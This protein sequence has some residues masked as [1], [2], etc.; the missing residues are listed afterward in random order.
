M[1]LAVISIPFLMSQYR[2]SANLNNMERT[3]FYKAQYPVV[4]ISRLTGLA[5]FAVHQDG[6]TTV[7]ISLPW[8]IYTLLLYGGYLYSFMI[9]IDVSWQIPL[10]RNYPFISVVGE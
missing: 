5:P 2:K 9:C 8:L 7:Q 10:S 3:Q 6:S 4:V 1:V